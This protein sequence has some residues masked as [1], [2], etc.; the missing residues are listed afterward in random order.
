MIIDFINRP[1]SEYGVEPMCRLLSERGCSI[2][3]SAK[4]P[5]ALAAGRIPQEGIEPTIQ[6]LVGADVETLK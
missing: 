2:A 6:S 1:K 4:A 5:L 3:P